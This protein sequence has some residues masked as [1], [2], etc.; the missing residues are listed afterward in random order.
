[1]IKSY[2]SGGR[3][4]LANKRCRWSQVKTHDWVPPFPLVGQNDSPR[5]EPYVGS[6]DVSFHASEAV[7]LGRDLHDTCM[8]IYG[9][10][11]ANNCDIIVRH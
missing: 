11:I 1:M 5:A 6:R 2:T 7:N 4:E 3:R 9:M 10:F 8:F